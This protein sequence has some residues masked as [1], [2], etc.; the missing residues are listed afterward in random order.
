MQIQ[1]K[2]RMAREK[3]AAL[4]AGAVPFRFDRQSAGFRTAQAAKF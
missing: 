3:P 2:K 1:L 4:A